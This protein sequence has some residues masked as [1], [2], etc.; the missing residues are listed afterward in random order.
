ML[1]FLLQLEP[2]KFLPDFD[3][4]IKLDWYYRIVV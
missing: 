1:N 4:L 2:D 3:N